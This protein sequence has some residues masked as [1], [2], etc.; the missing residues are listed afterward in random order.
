M[1]Y[2]V[3]PTRTKTLISSRIAAALSFLVINQGDKVSFSRF[4]EDL[5]EHFPAS[6]TRRHLM[7]ILAALEKRK[8]TK[9]TN[10]AASLNSARNIIK[11]RG[12]LVVI[13]DFWDDI[14]NTFDALSWYLH[15]RYEILLLKV[16]D[17][18][19]SSLLHG[20]RVRFVDMET[21]KSVDINTSQLHGPYSQAYHQRNINWQ[22]Q[23]QRRGIETAF[24]SSQHPYHSAIEAFLGV[25]SF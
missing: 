21:N 20:Q 15:H 10:L 19:E 14:E 17:P 16:N 13:S 23:A 4:A 25:K 3:D 12:R 5:V 22:E 9:R 2:G 11:K 8:R 7:H 6:G 24:I 1:N 18:G